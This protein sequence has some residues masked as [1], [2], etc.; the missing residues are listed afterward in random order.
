M[1]TFVPH[2]TTDPP[3]Q[4][5]TIWHIQVTASIAVL[6]AVLELVQQEDVF[7]SHTL[8]ENVLNIYLVSCDQDPHI[9]PTLLVDEI[10]NTWLE[11]T[12]TRSEL[13]KHKN[14]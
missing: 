7:D 9:I 11:A 6:Q 10:K 8:T 12:V 14:V 3:L 4:T 1:K 2:T 5:S 13:H